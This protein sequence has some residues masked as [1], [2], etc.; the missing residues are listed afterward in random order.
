[1]PRL[2]MVHEESPQSRAYTAR[3]HMCE[4]HFVSARQLDLQQLASHSTNAEDV[5]ATIGRLAAD[6]LLGPAEPTKEALNRL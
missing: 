2:F 6:Y 5:V 4:L 3:L 1:M